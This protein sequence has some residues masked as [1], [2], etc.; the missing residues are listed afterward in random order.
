MSE[1]TEHQELLLLY[2]VTVNDLSYFKTQQWAVATYAFLLYAG[3]GGIKELV[4]S[5]IDSIE[6]IILT[7]FAMSVLL[8][9]TIVITKLQDS[10]KV[11][12]ARL[13]ATQEHFG[14]KFKDAWEAKNKT[15]EYVPSVWFLYAAVSLGA[16]VLLYLIWRI[17][18]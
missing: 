1:E 6:R 11:R 14:K 10:I 13:D 12:Q 7:V 3:I 2:Q 4:G 16:V 17:Q 9:A 18:V 8:A 5:P 15:N